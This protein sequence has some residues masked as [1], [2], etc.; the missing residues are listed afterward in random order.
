MSDRTLTMAFLDFKEGLN[1]I[2]RQIVDNPVDVEDIVHEAYVRS[3]VASRKEHIDCPKA[4]IA[5]SARNL[6]L[7]HIASAH[8]LRNES[9]GEREFADESTCES[10][11]EDQLDAERNLHAYRLAIEQL[12]LQC[13]RVYTLKQVYGL[14]QKE[15]ASR[16]HISEKTVEYHISKGL[17]HCRRFLKE[18][19]TAGKAGA[20]RS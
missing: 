12:P 1:R 16:L 17:L 2:V 20:S 15:I 18:L 8:N 11:I 7:N 9:I 4:F 13:R 3:L 10:S 5:R 14:S 6:A 19:Q